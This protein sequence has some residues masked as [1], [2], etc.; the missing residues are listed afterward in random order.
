MT[1]DSID[2]S[3][4]GRCLIAMPDM[5]DD[6][7]R[8]ALIY[9]CTHSDEGAMGLIVN[10]PAS[11]ITLKDLLQQIS[12][13]CEAARS[14]DLV[15]FGGPVESGRGFVLHSTDYHS[16]LSSLKVDDA[17]SMTSTV[18]IL[19]DI[20]KGNGPKQA[21][22]ALG[23]AGWAP[24]QLEAEIASN[25]WLVVKPTPAL[26]FSTPHAAKWSEALRSLGFDPAGLSSS[27]GRA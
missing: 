4:T 20:G 14:D 3:L 18:D 22:C 21:L 16:G 11:E 2:S 5:P 26:I 9:V 17:F 8:N 27:G 24:R 23:Y 25:G 6:R 1:T 15:Y 10:K 13:E 19:E 12:I 7:F